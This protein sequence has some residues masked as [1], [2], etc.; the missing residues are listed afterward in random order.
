MVIIFGTG[1][2]SEIL[3][4]YKNELDINFFIDNNIDQIGSNRFLGYDVKSPEEIKNND[5]DQ[6]ILASLK[7]AEEMRG[8]LIGLGVDKHKIINIED[9]D[10]FS[11]EKSRDEIEKISSLLS[12]IKIRDI[13]DYQSLPFED[14]LIEWESVITKMVLLSSD[15]KIYYPGECRVC[16]KNVPM[17]IDNSCSGSPFKVNFREGLRCPFCGMNNRQRA[18]AGLILEDVS[19]DSTVYLTEQVTPMYQCL[20]KYYKHLIGSE[21]LGTDMRGRM[22]RGYVMRI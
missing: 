11:G 7:Y 12:D 8:Q 21:Y 2:I 17:K 10:F 15:K 6:I 5:F 13:Q 20:K 18:M 1:Y 19:E 3:M 22:S 9:L 4:L 16:N 14:M